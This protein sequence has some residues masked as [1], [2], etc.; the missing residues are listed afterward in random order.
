MCV[1]VCIYIFFP[2]A[3]ESHLHF[4]SLNT[5]FFPFFSFLATPQHVEL[6]GQGSDPSCNF[7]LS[8]LCQAED[9][10]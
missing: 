5:F 2:K 1:C 7:D 10:T 6:L 8:P 9:R 3:K 4:S